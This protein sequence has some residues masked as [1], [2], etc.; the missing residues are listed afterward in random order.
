MLGKKK[1]ETEGKIVAF[2]AGDV[3]IRQGAE[4]KMAYLVKKGHVRVSKKKG[5]EDVAIAELGRGQIVGEM[6]L[7]KGYRCA[8]TVTAID[9]VEAQP[10]SPAVI[11]KELAHMNLLM[12]QILTSLVERL[13]NETF[14]KK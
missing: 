14:V 8:A 6:A 9:D 11:N 12:Q 1:P 4:P 2:K 5:D 3:L 7:I 13:Y 10:I